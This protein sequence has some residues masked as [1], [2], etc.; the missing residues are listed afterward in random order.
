VFQ[1][2][3][4]Y[5][6]IVIVHDNDDRWNFIVE[7]TEKINNFGLTPPSPSKG[8]SVNIFPED[9]NMNSAFNMLS[10]SSQAKI[11]Q[12]EGG[13]RRIVMGQ[14]I[15]QSARQSGGNAIIGNTIQQNQSSN[16]PLVPYFE[17]LPVQKQLTA[18]QGG[19]NSM[20][21][22]FNTLAKS[23]HN[24]K[25]TIT[26]PKTVQEQLAG[27]LPLLSVDQKGGNTESSPS[28]TSLSTSSGT[29]SDN[30]TSESSSS[31]SSDSS[32]RKISFA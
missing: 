15:R 23:V 14:I 24:E 18:L 11:L 27:K 20:S 25:L 32:I 8:G 26:K 28:E 5:K 19:Y 16:R 1:F 29:S 3:D 10:G 30:T 4:H 22:E 12:M 7:Q 31:S 21:K 13:Q 9:P 17:A 2:Q 6:S